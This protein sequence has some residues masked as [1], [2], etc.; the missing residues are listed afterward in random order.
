MHISPT[1]P[2]PVSVLMHSNICHEFSFH[3][4]ANRRFGSKMCLREREGKPF[5]RRK[6][7]CSLPHIELPSLKE[8][9]VE[10]ATR[11]DSLIDFH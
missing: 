11:A 10:C 5:Y 7:H 3:E 4:T 1:F 2:D 8:E 6:E 9:E